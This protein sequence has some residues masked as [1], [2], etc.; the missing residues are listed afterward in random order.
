MANT[1]SPLPADYFADLLRRRK[2]VGLCRA[3]TLASR[4]GETAAASHRLGLTQYLVLGMLAAA[5]PRSQQEL[6]QGLRLDR[7]TMVSTVDALEKAGLLVRERNPQ[8]R[9][10]YITTITDAGRATLAAVDTDADAMEDEFFGRL[11]AAERTQLVD[12]L[13][14]ILHSG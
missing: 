12:L 13:T 3:G 5:G 6:S 2:I 11:S 7:T 9:R 1:G 4:L 10:A 8:D 14:K